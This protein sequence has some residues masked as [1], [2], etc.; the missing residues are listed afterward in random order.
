MEYDIE[1]EIE[2]RIT[3]K[4]KQKNQQNILDEIIVYLRAKSGVKCNEKTC[5]S[6]Q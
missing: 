5:R 4:N 3:T 2:L 1:P 6:H